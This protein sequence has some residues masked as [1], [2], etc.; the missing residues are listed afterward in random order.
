MA[1]QKVGQYNFVL[2]AYE[3]DDTGDEHTEVA[4]VVAII[5]YEL[6]KTG[7][8]D[9]RFVIAWMRDAVYS[10]DIPSPCPYPVKQFIV[11][12]E[13][14]GGAVRGGNRWHLDII[15]PGQIREPVFL[16]KQLVGD[17]DLSMDFPNGTQ[18][19]DVIAAQRYYYISHSRITSSYDLEA[20]FFKMSYKKVFFLDSYFPLLDAI[21]SEPL[22]TYVKPRS[23]A[24][25][26]DGEKK[27]AKKTK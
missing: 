9:T 25:K 14:Q 22:P 20:R 1:E 16:A 7:T 24:V 8:P 6:K 4:M 3:D 15:E 19:W 26:R 21:L 5:N 18:S 17:F 2:V 23:F 11:T 10:R 27:R 13:G 12:K